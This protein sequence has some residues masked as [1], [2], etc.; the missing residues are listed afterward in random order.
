MTQIFIYTCVDMFTL[1]WEMCLFNL[2][3]DWNQQPFSNKPTVLTFRSLLPSF[4]GS[5]LFVALFMPTVGH[6]K[7]EYIGLGMMRAY[8]R[9]SVAGGC[10][11]GRPDSA[12]WTVGD[13]DSWKWVKNTHLHSE[14]CRQPEPVNSN[15][16]MSKAPYDLQII[17]I[18]KLKSSNYGRPQRYSILSQFCLKYRH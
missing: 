4:N 15:L 17:I 16:W 13:T 3:K 11:E 1:C 7:W 18:C 9:N 2:P 14:P 12:E 8:K 5:V 6:S 10:G